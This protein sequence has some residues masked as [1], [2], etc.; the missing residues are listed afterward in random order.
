MDTKIPDPGR[1]VRYTG[2]LPDLPEVLLR[3]PLLT[4]L[5]LLVLAGPAAAQPP[6]EAPPPDLVALLNTPIISASRS[7]EQLSQAPATVIV[8]T[9]ADLES[10]GYT[11]LSQILDDLPGMDLS[12]S[13]GAN[14]F[15][16]YWRGYRNDIGDPFLVMVDGQ[17]LNHLWYGT[18]DTPLVTYPLSAVE[19]V[20]VVYGPASSV[21]GA[22]AFMGV[23][24]LITRPAPAEDGVAVRGQA[25]AGS[26]GSR[27]VDAQAA[28]RWGE[29]TVSLAVRGD[30][31]GMDTA[32]AE[33]T[34]FTRAQVYADPHVWGGFVGTPDSDH[35][36]RAVDLRLA[37]GGTE[38]GVQR[39]E[40]RSGYGYTY[41][42]DQSQSQ[43]V[44]DRPETNVFIRRTDDWSPTVRSTAL[45]RYRRSDLS[46]DSYDVESAY[47]QT[48]QPSAPGW[49][50]TRYQSLNSS[51]AYAQDFALKP[52]AWLD[53]NLGLSFE[54]KTLQKAYLYGT[55][56]PDPAPPEG[57]LS[58]ANHFTVET[59]GLYGQARARLGPGQQVHLG[60]RSDQHSIYGTATT[61][62]G[63]YVGTFGAWGLKALYGQAYQEPTARQLYGATIGTGANP[64]LEPER[65]HTT[66][67]SL[68]HTTPALASSLSLYR[69]RNSGKIQLVDGVVVNSGDQDVTGADLG[70]QWQPPVPGLRQ[71]KVWG[72]YSRL[73][74]A[75]DRLPAPGGTLTVRSGDLADHKVY[76]GTTVAW[77]ERVSGSLLARYEGRR[78]TVASN[79]VREV[80]AYATVDLALQVRDLPWRGVGLALRVANLLDRAYDH[81]GQRDAAAGLGPATWDGSLYTGSRSYYSS[82]LPQPGRSLQLSLT[83]AF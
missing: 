6:E 54:S 79:P 68:S 61:L 3:A 29:F 15:K 77:N 40:I 24:N 41:P 47:A 37:F 83:V 2:Q 13:Y 16:D 22:N 62:R 75:K 65:S 67:L 60:L 42:G 26:F 30:D 19:R 11:E 74:E 76:L 55:G 63:G 52:K 10:R 21:Y 18:A 56:S 32:S 36:H 20:E 80:P 23:I 66:E 57:S 51:L 4:T 64:D 44:W 73:L 49:L 27:I 69:V 48:G 28:A 50:L 33:R 71:W 5:A 72:W 34:P 46:D 8:L 17:A 59:R 78:P 14:Y 9:R 31:G 43:G 82:L 70:F 35:A 81:P 1:S 39:L 7:E 53:L 12:R 38:L 58:D 25:T 45:V